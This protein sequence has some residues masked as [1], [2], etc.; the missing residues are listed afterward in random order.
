MTELIHYQKNLIKH[1]LLLPSFKAK[2]AQF[3]HSDRLIAVASS[4]KLAVELAVGV[5]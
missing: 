4:T 2:V 5:A 3:G 1:V